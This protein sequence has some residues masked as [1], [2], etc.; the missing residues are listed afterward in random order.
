MAQ[1]EL[2]AR[3]KEFVQRNF[4][5]IPLA[6]IVFFAH[7]RI[8]GW[9]VETLMH[10]FAQEFDVNLDGFDGPRYAMDESL[11]FNFPKMVISTI[12]RRKRA[13]AHCFDVAHLIAVAEKGRWLD[14]IVKTRPKNG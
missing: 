10:D 13:S 3:V 9:D 12:F 2:E 7:P 5:D 1:P 4:P 6:E 11:L 8:A 14:P